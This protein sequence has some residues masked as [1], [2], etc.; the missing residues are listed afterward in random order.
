MIVQIVECEMNVRVK[1]ALDIRNE[2]IYN[3]KRKLHES[4]FDDASIA[5][6]NERVNKILERTC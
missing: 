6:R 3:Q 2:C 1:T 5:P 4:S